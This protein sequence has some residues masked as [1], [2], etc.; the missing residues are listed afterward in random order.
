MEHAEGFI[1][2]GVGELRDPFGGQVLFPGWQFID[3]EGTVP[4]QQ[5]FLGQ[6]NHAEL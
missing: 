5:G 4:D 3:T 6:G 1:V 2:Q